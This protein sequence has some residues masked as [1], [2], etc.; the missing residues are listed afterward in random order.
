MKRLSR[1]MPLFFFLVFDKKNELEYEKIGGK[2]NDNN[3]YLYGN[4]SI[5]E[6]FFCYFY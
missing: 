1:G 5:D 4:A 6:F 3:Y 2:Q